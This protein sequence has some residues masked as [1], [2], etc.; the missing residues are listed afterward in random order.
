M[1]ARGCLWITTYCGKARGRKLHTV[2]GR[3][4][5][6][7]YLWDFNFALGMHSQG[8]NGV[9]AATAVTYG[10]DSVHVYW[11]RVVDTCVGHMKLAATWYIE[12]S[13]IHR[14]HCIWYLLILRK[15]Q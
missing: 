10:S 6:I 1:L 2:V 3:H 9:P 14:R 4:Y 8:F 11:Q 13:G 15:A 7:P 12:I 5:T